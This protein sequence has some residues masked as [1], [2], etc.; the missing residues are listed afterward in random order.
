MFHDMPSE[1]FS[2]HPD[3]APTAPVADPFLRVR[4]GAFAHR[5]DMSSGKVI[6]SIENIA[7]D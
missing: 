4:A 1:I 7:V 6:Q 2:S 3:T 5:M